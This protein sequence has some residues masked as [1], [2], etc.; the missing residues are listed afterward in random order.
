MF[1]N[2]LRQNSLTMKATTNRGKNQKILREEREESVKA[3]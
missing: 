2:F 3:I 1:K